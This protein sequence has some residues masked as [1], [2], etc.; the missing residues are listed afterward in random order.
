MS[1]GIGS[2]CLG[3]WTI[4]TE[5]C[6]TLGRCFSQGKRVVVLCSNH[7]CPNDECRAVLNIT[8]PQRNLMQEDAIG[9]R[10]DSSRNRRHARRRQPAYPFNAHEGLILPEK[11]LARCQLYVHTRREKTVELIVDVKRTTL[12]VRNSLCARGFHFKRMPH[13]RQTTRYVALL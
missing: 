6:R 2:R 13:F 3:W 9:S 1:G 4:I 7:A 12:L 5:R 11:C 8:S 10:H